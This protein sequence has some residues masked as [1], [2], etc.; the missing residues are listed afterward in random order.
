MS[1]NTRSVSC[2]GAPPVPPEQFTAL[3]KHPQRLTAIAHLGMHLH[4]EPITDLLKRFDLDDFRRVLHSEGVLAVDRRDTR[5]GV[6]P[7][8][9]NERSLVRRASIQGASSPAETAAGQ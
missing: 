7:R 4:Q 3:A 9:S 1:R 6:Q 8:T 5:K 2:E